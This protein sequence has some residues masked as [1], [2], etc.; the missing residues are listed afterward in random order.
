MQDQSFAETL[1]KLPVLREMPLLVRP[2][3]VRGFE[4]LLL[5]V[6]FLVIRKFAVAVLRHATE[7]IAR[8]DEAAGNETRAARVRTLSSLTRSTLQYALGFIFLVSALGTIGF[9]VAGVLGTAGVAGLAVGFGAQK[10]VKDVISGFFLLLEDQYAV[11]DYVTVGSVSGV[12]EELGMRITRLRDDQGRLYILANGDINQVCN[13]SRG[14]IT[15]TLEIALA[16][17]ADL[18]QATAVLNAALV[19]TSTQLA[20]DEPARVEGVAAVDA[21]K[22]VLRVRFRA[23]ADA[24]LRPDAVALRLRETARAALLAAQIPLA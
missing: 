7:S 10:L 23:S 22:T 15:Q 6:L 9:N 5:L 14:P 12:V 1:F 19:H 13:Q 17:S 3:L 2:L 16:A 8:R 20:L 18:A 24:T 11:G 4:L 21:A